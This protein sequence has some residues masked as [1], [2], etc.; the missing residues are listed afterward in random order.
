MAECIDCIAPEIVCSNCDKSKGL[1]PWSS[2]EF[3]I[4][5]CGLEE[6]YYGCAYCYHHDGKWHSK[7]KEK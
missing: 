1:D 6:C 5:P 4:G 2:K 3:I 7:K